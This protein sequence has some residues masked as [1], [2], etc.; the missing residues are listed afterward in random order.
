MPT[1]F[2]NKERVRVLLERLAAGETLTA[3]ELCDLLNQVL[4]GNR[5]SDYNAE[6]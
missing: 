2:E 3:A 1:C 5:G 4:N 6:G